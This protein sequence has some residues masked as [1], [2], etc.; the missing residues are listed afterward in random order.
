MTLH[1]LA[2][3]CGAL[4]LACG[5]LG[6]ALLASGGAVGRLVKR[7]LGVM[8]LVG[9]GFL[10]VSAWDLYSYQREGLTPIATLRFARLAPQHFQAELQAQDQELRVFELH[11]DQWQVDARLLRPSGWVSRWWRAPYYRLERLSGRYHRVEDELSRPRSV[12]ALASESR[13]DVGDW[14]ERVPETWRPLQ[15]GYG[16]GAFLPMADGA[17]YV[18]YIDGRGLSANPANDA[19]R[20]AVN[21]WF[22]D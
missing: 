7:L 6:L 8:A 22:R 19:A 16:S 11:G 5:L 14:L 18:V 17:E 3:T 13:L 15:L 21:R 9:G 4:A 12:Y 1:W 10:G 20:R 2:V